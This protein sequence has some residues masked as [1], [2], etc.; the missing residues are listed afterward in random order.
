M[1]LT[2]EQ[3][4]NRVE[5]QVGREV[6]EALE[7]SW[8]YFWKQLQSDDSA[9]KAIKEDLLHSYDVVEQALDHYREVEIDPPA[10]LIIALG[11]HDCD[12]FYPDALELKDFS[13]RNAYKQAHAWFSAQKAREIL[14][15]SDLEPKLIS[16]IL[17]R[18]VAHH[19]D[20]EHDQ[21]Q[22]V[23]ENL[24]ERSFW[25]VYLKSYL[26][27]I[28]KDRTPEEVKDKMRSKY[29]DLSDEDREW[30]KN[31]VVEIDNPV[32]QRLFKELVEEFP[33]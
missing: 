19:A 23:F 14:L 13:N 5:E 18:I 8:K 17:A 12:R 2:R 1:S 28:G 7:E 11:L 33:D 22:R 6:R 29:I 4:L 30:V 25:R 31:Q 27:R 32:L 16:R 24:D 26:E 10:D 20:W 21:F 3:L 15:K 9:I